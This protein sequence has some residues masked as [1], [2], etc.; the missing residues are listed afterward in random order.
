MIPCLFGA[1]SRDAATAPADILLPNDH[2]N[3]KAVSEP[4]VVICANSSLLP[5]RQYMSSSAK[6]LVVGALYNTSDTT[7][8]PDALVGKKAPFDLTALDGSFILIKVEHHPERT[9]VTIATDKFG[10]RRLYYI[11]TEDYVLF[12]THLFGFYLLGRKKDQNI[13]DDIL[14]HYYNFGFTPSDSSLIAG[15]KKLPAGSLLTVENDRQDVRRYFDVKNLYRPQDY[16]ALDEDQWCGRIDNAL[17][18]GVA[19]RAHS[20][21]EVG[22]SL[23]GG[24]DSGYIAQKLT[25]TGAIVF[26]YNISYKDYYDEEDRVDFLAKSLNINVRKIRLDADEII[27]NF[28]QVSAS[29]SEPAALNGSIM[30]FAARQARKDGLAKLFDGDGADRLFLGMNRYIGYRRAIDLYNRA[31]R[32]GMTGPLQ[33]ILGMLPGDE[34]Q[35]F[36]IL[37]SNW[38]AGIPPYPER[39]LGGVRIY[40]PDYEWRVFQLGAQSYFEQFTRDFGAFDFGSYFT[41]QS[42]HMCPEMF[43]HGASEMMTDLGISP[44]PAFF[45]DELVELAFNIPT[46]WKLHGNT[47]KYILRKAAARHMDKE[48]WMLPKIGLQSALHYVLQT[49]RGKQWYGSLQVKVL[50]SDEYKTLTTLAKGQE[51]ETDRLVSL[52]A[53]KDAQVGNTY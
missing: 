23:S 53:W 5:L 24:V 41:Y 17:A 4:A 50:D 27:E 25:Q 14:L 13:Q 36:H 30:R 49:D 9:C 35:K 11:N 42:V 22:I 48:Y 47:T 51:I 39:K 29:S 52:M 20:G 38:R 37:V 31:A 2:A 44:I 46:E 43:F 19:H 33:L 15:T 18:N 32:F 16:R 7:M 6:I 10:T 28:E 21:E 1:I 45:T 26:G 3:I 8:R 12:S 34:I 40:D